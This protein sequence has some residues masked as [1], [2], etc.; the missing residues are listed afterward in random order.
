MYLLRGGD[1]DRDPAR[2][3]ERVE[4]QHVERRHVDEAAARLRPLALEQAG[5][6][7]EDVVT[8]VAPGVA[9]GAGRDLRLAQRR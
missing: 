6:R 1:R 2:P 3:H 8:E 4:R 7:V 9:R 5:E